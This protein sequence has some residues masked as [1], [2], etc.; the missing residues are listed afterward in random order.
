MGNLCRRCADAA[1]DS[2]DQDWLSGAEPSLGD[3]RIVC[4]QE[5]L[6]NRRRRHEVEVSRDWHGHP[7]RRH[8]VLGLCS[9]GHDAE[10]T[11]A[12]LERPSYIWPKRID[13]AC[14]LQAGNVRGNSRRRWVMAAGL[15]HVGSVQAAS[16][17]AHADPVSPWLGG[18]DLAK[19]ENL[20]PA[21]SS[22]H[23]GFHGERN[24][25]P[26]R[27]DGRDHEDHTIRM[28]EEQFPRRDTPRYSDR[29][30]SNHPHPRRARRRGG[31]LDRQTPSRVFVVPSKRRRRLRRTRVSPRLFRQEA[32]PDPPFGLPRSPEAQA[33]ARSPA[34]PRR[35]TN[36][37]PCTA[38]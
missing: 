18:R 31:A 38:G 15:Q 34:V 14:V 19:F 33:R 22:D 35:T 23:N 20:G 11:I 9:S 36:A 27:P 24:P 17:H 10:D 32:R 13:L 30:P 3:Q 6:G 1:A 37:Q 26:W 16:S 4:G 5:D 12:N 21:D 7:L 29:N 2:L 28:T 8:Q 25:L